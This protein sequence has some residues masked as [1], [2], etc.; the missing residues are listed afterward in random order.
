MARH[1]KVGRSGGEE[2]KRFSSA[3]D[4]SCYRPSLINVL[5]EHRIYFVARYVVHSIMVYREFRS[6]IF[7]ERI[8]GEIR[9]L[10][11]TRK[12]IVVHK[13]YLQTVADLASIKLDCPCGQI[14]HSRRF[15]RRFRCSFV[16][17]HHGLFLLF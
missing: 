13:S 6:H 15:V 10:V 2:I 12:W 7:Q 16:V 3:Y 17:F 14:E 9:R 11:A 5:I 4:S 1:M 8:E